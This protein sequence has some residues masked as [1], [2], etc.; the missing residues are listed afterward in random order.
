MLELGERIKGWDID[1]ES[2]LPLPGSGRTPARHRALLELGRKDL[3][4]ARIAEAHTDA[5]AIL[6]EGGRIPRAG[7]LYGVWASDGPQ[8]LVEATRSRSGDW[9]LDGVKQYCSGAMFATSA[10]VSAHVEDE[11]L[12]FDVPVDHPGIRILPSTWATPALAD[13][14]TA[15]VSFNR[16]TLAAHSLIGSANWYLT[17]PGFWHG[18]IGPA[19][20][21]AGGAQSLIDA[22]CALNRRDPHSRA[23]L[24]ALQAVSW[25][26]TAVLDQAGR[27]IDE[28]PRDE[29]G[30]ARTRAL[31]LRHL[32][33]RW[34]A[35]VLD[36]FGRAT[37]PQ[38]LC[39]D[40]QIARQHMALTVYMRQCHGE[41]D[42]E[43]I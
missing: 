15:P 31:K 1:D 23:H 22:A 29:H 43:T 36:R 3:S 9:R 19:A 13:T 38:L 4:L 8:S 17:R 14:A 7:T 41:R 37:G 25:G 34:C 42:L 28:D 2:A 26:L 18:A 11:V 21:W 30:E 24:G 32:I 35:E 6:A 10:L 33:E 39:F 16:V 20:C 27:E 5:L 40:S 12:L